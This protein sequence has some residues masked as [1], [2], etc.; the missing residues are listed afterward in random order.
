LNRH[1]FEYSIKG[2][3]RIVGNANKRLRKR[4]RKRSEKDLGAFAVV[5]GLLKRD[6]SATG[7]VREFR[8]RATT[9]RRQ[10]GHGGLL[11]LDN[12]LLAVV[13]SFLELQ[14]WRQEKAWQAH[15]KTVFDCNYVSDT[16]IVSGSNDHS[17]KIWTADGTLAHTLAEHTG[18]V[19]ACHA[20][21]GSN[22][23]VSASRDCTLNVWNSDSGALLHRL[24]GHEH[25]VECCAF[26]P[27]GDTILSCDLGCARLWDANSGIGLDVAEVEMEA[28][29]N[30]D[31]VIRC[32]CFSKDGQCYVL[33]CDDW[34]LKLYDV[35]SLRLR[36]TF[37]GHLDKIKSCDFSPEGDTLLSGSFDRT[38][39]VWRTGTGQLLHTLAGHS[40]WVR[41]CCFSPSGR[42]I[43]SASDDKTLVLWDAFTGQIIHIFD[44]QKKTAIS[45]AFGPDGK[46]VL[47]GFTG[48]F[49]C[50][51]RLS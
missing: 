27:T 3:T 21:P 30:E 12:Y 20:S 36:R 51:W 40:A 45:C 44:E 23:I 48:G 13:G 16:A 34:S 2:L 25:A 7:G 31:C 9:G 37:N 47:G 43:L 10:A 28:Y 38:M 15:H 5:A 8:M 39:K 33:G 17:V 18:Y 49:L 29:E 1:N 24:M 35:A 46:S 50:L 14:V 42:Q 41:Q 4:Q 6:N 11:E 32:C 19:T 22:L 26:S